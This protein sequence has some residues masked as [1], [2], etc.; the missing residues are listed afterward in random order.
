LLDG[1]VVLLSFCKYFVLEAFIAILLEGAGAFVFFSIKF[2]Y[3][4]LK[5]EKK[6]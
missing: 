2:S 6:N 1:L 3:R 4:I 5:K